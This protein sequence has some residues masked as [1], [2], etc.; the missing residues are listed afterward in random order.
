M[1]KQKGA[2]KVISDLYHHI[3]AFTDVFSEDSFY[4]CV[5]IFVFSTILVAFILSKFITLKPVED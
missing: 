3:P 2:H 5:I 1:G 4:V